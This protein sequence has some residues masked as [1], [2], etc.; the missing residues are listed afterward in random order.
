MWRP[1]GCRREKSGG[2][3]KQ[4][5]GG[6]TTDVSNKTIL[7][8][9]KYGRTSGPKGG[10]KKAA[11]A[12]AGTALHLESKS[13]VSPRYETECTVI[14]VRLGEKSKWMAH[15]IT[16]TSRHIPLRKHHKIAFGAILNAIGPILTLIA[17]P[18]RR[19]EEIYFR[20]NSGGIPPDGEWPG[21]VV[22]TRAPCC[23]DL[24]RPSSPFLRRGR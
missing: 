2:C 4:S 14:I 5:P 9:R 18:D 6:G 20:G 8:A 17:P 12:H 1:Q 16:Y 10:R 13:S 15:A 21:L 24:W 11:P 19:K 7:P 3:I 23:H 22:A